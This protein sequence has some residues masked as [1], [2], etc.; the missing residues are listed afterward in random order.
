MGFFNIYR[1]FS[2]VEGPFCRP[3]ER[4]EDHTAVPAAACDVPGAEERCEETE[5]ESSSSGCRQ[6]KSYSSKCRCKCR[7]KKKKR[8]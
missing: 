6:E 4:S 2:T 3:Q 8:C 5:K 7:R 1:R